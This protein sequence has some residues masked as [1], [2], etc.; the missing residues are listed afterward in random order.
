MSHAI[1]TRTLGRSGLEVSPLGL[2]C[3]AIGGPFRDQGGWMGYGDVDDATSLEALRVALDLGVTLLDVSDVYGCGHAERLVGEALR[4]RTDPVVLV[5][6]FGYTF[7]EGARQVT[8]RDLSPGSI[9]RSCEASLTRLGV[10]ALDVY[11][12]HPWDLS[13]DEALEVRRVLEALADEGKIRGYGWCTED[14]AMQRAFAAGAPRCVVAPQVLNWMQ[15]RPDLLALA[16]ELDLAVI[17]RRP[18]GM[19]LLTG[20]FHADRELAANDMRRRF[21]WDLRA[22]KQAAQLARLDELRG[23]L[24]RRGH[25]LAQAALA[26]IW[27]RHPRAVPVPGFRNR[28]QVEE[29]LGARARGPLDASQMQDLAGPGPP[30]L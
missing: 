16:D 3:W 21:G 26:W 5:S 15:A 22:G 30:G 12:L 14:P 20:A 13:L 18:L 19:G 10:E 8:G 11:V 25:T 1:G 29:N 6:K 2:G 4:G 17:T 28:A 24:T 9:R 7:D 23:V 27:A